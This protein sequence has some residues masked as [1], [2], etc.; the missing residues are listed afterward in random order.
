MPYSTA[1]PGSG[2]ASAGPFQSRFQAQKMTPNATATMLAITMSIV[3]HR[4]EL[5]VMMS[6]PV[7]PRLETQWEETHAA[8]LR[9]GWRRDRAS[10]AGITQIRYEGLR[11]P[12]LSALCAPLSDRS[13]FA[14]GLDLASP[15]RCN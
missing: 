2:M 1:R 7:W 11:L 10:C 5:V 14:T 15:E 3:R 9:R 8:A 12:A 6:L 4:L 13:S